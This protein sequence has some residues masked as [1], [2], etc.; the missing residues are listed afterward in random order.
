MGKQVAA[1]LLYI[2][3]SVMRGYKQR[4]CL[5]LLMTEEI[6]SGAS[7]GSASANA[8]AG[9]LKTEYRQA[10]IVCHKEGPTKVGTKTLYDEKIQASKR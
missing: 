1:R 5:Q 7:Y 4:S 3:S 8:G 9:A 6:Q 2:T 10:N